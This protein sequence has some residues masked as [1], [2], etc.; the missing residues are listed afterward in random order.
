MGLVKIPLHIVCLQTTLITSMVRV[1]VHDQLL[2][3]GVSMILG[4]GGKV[5]PLLEVNRIPIQ[6]NDPTDEEFAK[7][8][9]ACAV[10]W[11]QSQKKPRLPISANDKDGRG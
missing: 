6:L 7:K 10:T 3:K 11:A 2:V 9:P 1:G 8:A 4:N 5:T